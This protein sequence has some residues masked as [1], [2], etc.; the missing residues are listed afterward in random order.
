MEEGEASS[1]VGG[2]VAT[3]AAISACF[4]EWVGCPLIGREGRNWTRGTLCV[5]RV[6]K[7]ELWLR[8]SA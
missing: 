7:I 5:G 8:C 4:I 1:A 2:A 3:A 6:F